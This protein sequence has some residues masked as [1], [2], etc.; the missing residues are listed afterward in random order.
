MRQWF[1]QWNENQNWNLH[2]ILCL[3]LFHPHPPFFFFL[4]FFL[5]N[6]AMIVSFIHP[7]MKDM[8]IYI[9]WHAGLNCLE[10]NDVCKVYLSTKMLCECLSEK[11]RILPF[12]ATWYYFYIHVQTP[13][14]T[15]IKSESSVWM[16]FY[17]VLFVFALELGFCTACTDCTHL[18]HTT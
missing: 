4:F 5:N 11:D 16:N 17:S 7:P 14:N 12:G 6:Q 10:G 9:Y 3:F 13:E 2:P 18:Q 8:C 1:K 15:L